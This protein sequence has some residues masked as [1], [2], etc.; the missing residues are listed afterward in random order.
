MLG[1]QK[2]SSGTTRGFF[3]LPG[4]TRDN[5]IF[6]EDS[7]DY[8]FINFFKILAK[9]KGMELPP[10]MLEHPDNAFN[11]YLRNY[12]LVAVVLQ[13]DG[14]KECYS[15]EYRNKLPAAFIDRVRAYLQVMPDDTVLWRDDAFNAP[16]E[17]PA[18]EVI[19]GQRPEKPPRK[20]SRQ[21]VR[22]HW[23]H[24]GGLSPEEMDYL[25]GKKKEPPQG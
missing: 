1:K 3:Y 7:H 18:R 13:P 21:D 15:V 24:P 25:T 14:G 12:G 8:I 6:A 10:P 9:E 16:Q 4:I 22:K 20:P 17:A 2:S 11:E 23:A 19:Y 5:G